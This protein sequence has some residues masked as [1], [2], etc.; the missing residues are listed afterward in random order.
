VAS[1]LLERQVELAALDAAVER[2][3]RGHGST[4]LVLGEA[5]IGK[6]SL[7]QAF[8]DSVS[9][10]ARVLSGAGEDLLTPRALGPVRDAARSSTGP[11]A[12][13]LRASADPDLVF[14]AICD[15][16]GVRPAP[17]VFV[18]EDVH[19]A[20]GATLDVLRYL[21]RRIGKLP[22]LLLLTYRDDDLAPDHPLRGVLGGF[23]G[24]ALR[25]R[26]APLTTKAVNELAATT[27]MDAAELVR[28]TGG[29]P[30]FVTEALASADDAVPATVVDAVLARVRRMSPLAQRAIERLAVVPSGVEFGLLRALV[31]DLVP[32]AE[33]ERAGV[34]TMHEGVVSF[35]HELARRAVVESLPA[36]LRLELNAAVVR[37]RPRQLRPLPRAAPWRRER[38]RRGGGHLRHAGRTGGHAPRCT[39]SSGVLLR[40]GARA[41]IPASAR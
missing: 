38:R 39:P 12:D 37:A 14:A 31:E 33:A 19:W 20:D 16:L 35:R 6:T 23:G 34:L 3:A 30:F 18:V 5:G 21:G 2:A 26:L 8:L 7:V 36:S 13:A 11:L 27:T 15:E 41:R 40:P 4:A 22:G 1:Y 17:T 25:L 32:V 10:S 29:N 9:G 28:L 24:S